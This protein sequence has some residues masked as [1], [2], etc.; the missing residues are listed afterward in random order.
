MRGPKVFLG[1][2][3][4]NAA[5]ANGFTLI[6]LLVVIAIIA[7]LAGMLLP[8]LG[9]AKKQ[10]HRTQCA[11]NLR[12]IGIAFHL[13]TDENKGSFPTHNGWAS[14]GGIRPTHPVTTGTSSGYGS[15]EAETRRPLNR[16]LSNPNVF[17]CP[18]DRGDNYPDGT[19]Q[20]CFL[21]YLAIRSTPGYQLALVV[22]TSH[23]A[24]HHIE[25]N[26]EMRLC[27]TP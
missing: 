24:A 27:K 7:V 14:L 1:G 20:N 15:D 11:S 18:A 13:Y 10:A 8:A 22:K 2:G 5:S 21:S 6:E 26:P 19:V 25:S 3:L 4:T 12:Q 17:R 16:Y 9:R 23:A